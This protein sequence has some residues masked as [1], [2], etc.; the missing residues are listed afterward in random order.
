MR[1]L[2]IL[3]LSVVLVGLFLWPVLGEKVVLRGNLGTEPPTADP[4]L[5]TDT[6]SV[7]VTEQ[8]F[9]GLTDLAE[10]DMS[11]LPELATHWE[12]SED[13]LQI[14]FYMRKDVHWV[15]CD[16]ETGEV[17]QLDRVVNAHDVVYGVK[18][19]LDPRTASDYAYVL[20]I[21]KGAS[22][23]NNADPE[24]ENF[25]ELMDN[26]GVEALDDFTVRF[27]LRTPAAYFLQ[28]ASMWVARPQPKWVIEEYG[29]AWTEPGNIV[30][31]GP[32][33]MKEWVHED[34]M[35]LVKNPYWPDWDKV[36]GNIDEIYLTMVEEIS[37]EFAMYLNDEL[38]Y[39]GVPLPEMDN[40]KA[41]PVLS[42]Q[43]TIRPIPCTY[44]YGF[45]TTK[46]P[47]DDPRVRR[48]LS[49]AIDRKTLVE[50]V[51]K[52][53]QIPA[54]TFAPS[55]IFGNA[56]LDPG[57]APWALPE[58]LGG[59]GYERALEEARKLMAEAGYPDGEGLELLLMHNVSEGHSRI[60]QAI[61][62]MWL[63]AFPKAKI[64]IETQE[65]K[66]YLKT[67]EKET[68]VENVPHIWRLGWCQDYP[69]ENNWVHEVFN[70]VEGANRPRM[71]LDDPYVGDLIKRF[72]DLT[73]QA[74]MEQDPEVRKQLYWEAEKLLCDDIAAIAPIYYYTQVTLTK[75]WLTRHWHDTP[76]FE[77]WSIDVEARAAAIGG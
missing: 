42:Q 71:S 13:G 44:Y 77:T 19:T 76:H 26:V 14:T 63:E 20:Y 12:F 33:C 70:P 53:G 45:T 16:P 59:W 39:G 18:R 28:I 46:P 10:E 38:D 23:F 36:P 6:T 52:G 30:T 34:H 5:A 41:D 27:T 72:A 7:T 57:I 74:Q 2:K 75:P 11:P 25:Q 65:W 68:P 40:V 21:I 62:A 54:N 64:T 50:E 58:E 32:Y 35:V 61:Q 69:D 47:V 51:T 4:A 31:N 24:A 8:L 73:L 49:M 56:A 37:T 67:I 55:M 3:G 17:T 15:H 22:D 60:A 1:M 43:L 66:V 48:A 29:E 9:L